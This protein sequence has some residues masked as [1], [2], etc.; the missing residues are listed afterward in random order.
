MLQR[1]RYS[2]PGYKL[3]K[4]NDPTMKSNENEYNHQLIKT[5]EKFN[6]GWHFKDNQ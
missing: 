3:K 1:K 6:D 4:I 5:R 2:N